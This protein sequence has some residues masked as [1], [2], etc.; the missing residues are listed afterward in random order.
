MKRREGEGGVR[1]GE[2]EVLN[3]RSTVGKGAG[4]HGGERTMTR[5]KTIE[6]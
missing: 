4:V 6:V 5:V 3:S 2:G 1:R